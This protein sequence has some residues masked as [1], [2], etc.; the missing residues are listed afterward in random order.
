MLEIVL[1]VISAVACIVGI[2]FN[3]KMRKQRKEIENQ[4][5]EEIRKLKNI[6]KK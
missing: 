2:I 4:L 3:I 6:N 5:N 1:L